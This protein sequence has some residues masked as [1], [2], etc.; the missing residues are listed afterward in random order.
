MILYEASFLN[1]HTMIFY[2]LLPFVELQNQAL[3]FYRSFF[4]CWKISLFL[5]AIYVRYPPL[6]NLLMFP[7]IVLILT[8]FVN[9]IIYN[10]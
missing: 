5:S 7:L 3:L 1:L 2:N 4:T 10:R 9:D 6:K 8:N